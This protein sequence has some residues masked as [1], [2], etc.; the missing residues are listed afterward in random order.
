[1]ANASFWTLRWVVVALAVFAQVYLFL[2][3]RTAVR[4]WRAAG[5]WGLALVGAT[6]ILITVLFAANWRIMNTPI[7]WVDPS[8]AAQAVFFY[9]PAIWG[10]GSILSALL[11]LILQAGGGLIRAGGWLLRRARGAHPAPQTDPGRRRFLKA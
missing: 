8:A 7:R 9:A 4:Q 1:M 5:R 10:F 6:G 2:R 3:I 11:L